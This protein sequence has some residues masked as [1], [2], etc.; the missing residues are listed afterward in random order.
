MF[1]PGGLWHVLHLVPGMERN[2]MD[3]SSYPA[4]PRISVR[5]G[6]TNRV[7]RGWKNSVEPKHNGMPRILEWQFYYGNTWKHHETPTYMWFSIGTSS[8]HGV[9]HPPVRF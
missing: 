9:R 7:E 5:C 2:A 4:G 3:W 8:I 1:P 6:R